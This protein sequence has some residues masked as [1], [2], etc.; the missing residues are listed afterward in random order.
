MK[1]IRDPKQVHETML[2]LTLA[3]GLVYFVYREPIA[4]GAAIGLCFTGLFL[5]WVSEWITT[6]WMGLAGLLG[7][8]SSAILMFVVFFVLITP[9]SL[10]RRR[11]QVPEHKASAFRERDHIFSP[12]DLENPW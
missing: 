4:L 8:I 9:V 6:A 2:V 7:Q 5:P 1:I 3:S 12:A 11:K 10:L